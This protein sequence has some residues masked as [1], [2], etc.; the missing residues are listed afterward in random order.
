MWAFQRE[1]SLPSKYFGDNFFH[2]SVGEDGLITGRSVWSISASGESKI[3]RSVCEDPYRAKT[4]LETVTEDMSHAFRKWP[5]A[6]REFWDKYFL[7]GI[8][9]AAGFNR[10]YSAFHMMTHRWQFFLLSVVLDLK[11]N[12]N[13]PD[14]N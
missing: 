2:A 8:R 12:A 10:R 1:F 11:K 7:D 13:G 6:S 3:T 14:D 9:T 4:Q 5:H